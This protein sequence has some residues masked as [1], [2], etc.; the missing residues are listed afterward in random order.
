MKEKLVIAP[1]VML[2]GNQ[3]GDRGEGVVTKDLEAGQEKPTV[4]MTVEQDKTIAS[5]HLRPL[6]SLLTVN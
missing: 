3:S 6:E 5:S 1:L 2:F 4:D